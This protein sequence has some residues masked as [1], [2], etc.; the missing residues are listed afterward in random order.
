[1]DNVMK[2][3]KGMKCSSPKCRYG[4]MVSPDHKCYRGCAHQVKDDA[5][6]AAIENLKCIM[7]HLFMDGKIIE[8]E[9][10]SKARGCIEN[11]VDGWNAN[12]KE[13]P[14]EPN[15]FDL[16]KDSINQDY[17]I[18]FKKEL[19]QV[20][21]RVENLKDNR[22][23]YQLLLLPDHFYEAKIIDCI[24][25]IISKVR[26]KKLVPILKVVADLKV[27][28]NI[29]EQRRE[30]ASYISG[31][32]IFVDKQNTG[33]LEVLSMLEKYFEDKDVEG[34]Y[35]VVSPITMIFTSFQILEG[36]PPNA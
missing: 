14:K 2:C 31:S 21:I 1:M 36:K 11:F 17:K 6:S 30:D 9:L 20:Y 8:G 19:N 10:P 16:I 25:Y 5:M 4:S 15:L 32:E 18:S 22:N 35:M 26:T 27:L 24:H 7:P 13:E 23:M 12:N 33:R 28:F 29:K 34:G 3:E